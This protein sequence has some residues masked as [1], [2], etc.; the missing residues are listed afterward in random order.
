MM[1]STTL[2]TLRRVP[3]PLEIGVNNVF[4]S[5]CMQYDHKDHLSLNQ[6]LNVQLKSKKAEQEQTVQVIKTR[7]NI[8][9][10]IIVK[11]NPFIL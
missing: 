2:I 7:L 3:T 11:L 1:Y 10:L 8:F 4:Y 5:F 9:K 6:K